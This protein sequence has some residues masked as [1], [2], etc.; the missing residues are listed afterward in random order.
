MFKRCLFALMLTGLLYA[1]TPATA[2]QDAAGS[3]QQSAPMGEPPEHG[4]GHRHFDPAKRTEMLTKHL[5][6]SSDQ[7]TKV[8]DILMSEQ[9][10]MEKLHSDSS[11][12]QDD[13]RS[14]MMDLHKS[15]ND[16]VRAL[17]NADQQKKWDAMQSKHEQSMQGHHPHGQGPGAAPDSL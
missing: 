12:S 16:Q 14:K 11:M 1:V 7:Q 9:S 13:R 15:S 6:L 17:L 10:Q 8:R 3:E 4:H 2:A 5:N